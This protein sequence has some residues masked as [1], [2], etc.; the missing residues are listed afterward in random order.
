MARDHETQKLK[1]MFMDASNIVDGPAKPKFDDEHVFP[2]D[3]F[4]P[5]QEEMQL[6]F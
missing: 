4:H 5:H 6:H 2:H 3:Q 1:K